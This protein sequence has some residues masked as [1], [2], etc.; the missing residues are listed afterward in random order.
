MTDPALLKILAA[1]EA[2]IM[3]VDAAW[4]LGEAKPS[5]GLLCPILRIKYPQPWMESRDR[6]VQH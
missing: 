2:G 4:A 5:Y 3:S 1:V 6:P